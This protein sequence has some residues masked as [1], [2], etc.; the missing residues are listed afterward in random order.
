MWLVARNPENRRG[1]THGPGMACEKGVYGFLPALPFPNFP[2]DGYQPTPTGMADTKQF[3][4]LSFALIALSMP[5]TTPVQAQ[6]MAPRFGLG[7]ATMLSTEDGLGLGFHGRASAPVNADLSFAVD[8][9][10]VGFILEGRD[11]ATYIFDPQVSAIIT[12]PGVRSAPYVLGGVGGYIPLN[13]KDRTVSGPTIHLGIGWVRALN[14][15]SLFYE[16][17]PALIIGET[18]VQFALPF[19]LGL[20][21]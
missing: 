4:V 1:L 13:D 19:R 2:L 7:F 14:E 16:L 17:N 3:I 6:S 11:E 5:L 10:F 9:G 21:F 18:N 12:L 8:L 15:T 20:I